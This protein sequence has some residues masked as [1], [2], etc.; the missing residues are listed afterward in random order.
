LVRYALDLISCQLSRCQKG[1]KKVPWYCVKPKK[2]ALALLPWA[3][4]K[5][6]EVEMPEPEFPFVGLEH[7]SLYE[8]QLKFSSRSVQ[9]GIEVQEYKNRE[10]T[11]PDTTKDAKFQL[12]VSGLGL[13]SL[14]HLYNSGVLPDHWKAFVEDAIEVARCPARKKPRLSSIFQ[15]PN[16]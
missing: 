1:K 12:V 5:L 3:V 11:I 8:P 2:M 16:T 14:S 15:A 13:D 4:F 10:S 9:Q 6:D 7:A